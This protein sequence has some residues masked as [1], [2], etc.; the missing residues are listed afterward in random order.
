MFSMYFSALVECIKILHITSSAI[1]IEKI[2][3]DNIRAHIDKIVDTRNWYTHFTKE[4]EPL[5]AKGYELVNL[6]KIIRVL[7][8]VCL[9]KQ[10][11]MPEELIIQTIKNTYCWTN[12]TFILAGDK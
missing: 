2:F 7:F 6:Y 1:G 5:A 11:K 10:L 4:L 8:E 12:T 3:S 9:F